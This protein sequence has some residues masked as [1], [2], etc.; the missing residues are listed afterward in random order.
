[1]KTLLLVIFSV[2]CLFVKA[3]INITPFL[4]EDIHNQY[5][6]AAKILE[7]KMNNIISSNGIKSEMGESRF[8]LTG[9][10][11]TETKD[12][13]GGAPTQIAYTL[14][15]NLYIGDGEEGTK[16]ISETFRV[17]GVGS[18]EEKAHLAAIRNLQGNSTKMSEFVKKGKERII[19][20]YESNKAKLHANIRSLI[21]KQ[22]YDEAIYQLCLIPMECSYYLEAQA[23]IDDVYQRIIDNKSE[24]IFT[25]AKAIW[26]SA[27]TADGANRVIE[28]VSQ[29]DPNASCFTSVQK[30]ISNV[31]SKINLINER[32]YADY[33]K[34]LAHSQEMEKLNLEVQREQNRLNAE[35]AQT[36]IKADASVEKTR[37]ETNAKN[38][39]QYQ[40]TE[41]EKNQQA[42]V[43]ISQGISASERLQ[44]QR[45]SAA[46]DI[47]V[48]YAQNRP[49]I[50]WYNVND[51]Y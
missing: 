37:L 46:R 12:I 50:V 40:K 31:T 43:L 39:A 49:K 32:A 1:M 21:T 27:Q 8:I 26:A 30:F 41:R 10:W 44:S 17:K 7:G 51:W 20:Y 4:P 3:Q 13:V 28:L 29:I 47:A 6:D 24:R 36:Q 16:Y 45:I 23:Q 25:E 19:S 34:K 14:N 9:N 2:Y 35:V 18:T 42:T 22:D 5:P 48:T 11:V 15:I 38:Y 33:Q